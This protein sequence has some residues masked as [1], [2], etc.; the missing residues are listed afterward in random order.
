[1]PFYEF[2]KVDLLSAVGLFYRQLP[3]AAIALL[4]SIPLDPLRKLIYEIKSAP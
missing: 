1:M 4:P 3:K 2:I